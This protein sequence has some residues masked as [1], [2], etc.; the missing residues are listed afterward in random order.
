MGGVSTAAVASNG[1]S[2]F[3]LTGAYVVF[4][5]LPPSHGNH[6]QVAMVVGDAASAVPSLRLASCFSE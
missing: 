5:T 3:E 2:G 6:A 1:H 4:E